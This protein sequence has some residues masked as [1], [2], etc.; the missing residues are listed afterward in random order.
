LTLPTDKKSDCKTNGEGESP[1]LNSTDIMKGL[2]L[3]PA[4]TDHQKKLLDTSEL[5]YKRY[6]RL[7]F[8]IISFE[9]NEITIKAF[10]RENVAEKYLTSKEIIERVH[11]VFDVLGYKVHVRPITFKKDDLANVDTAYVQSKMEALS[12]G[13]KDLVKLLNIDKSSLSLILSEGRMTRSNQAMFY[14][15]FKYLEEKGR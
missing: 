3:L 4:L 10:Q 1:L 2:E 8:E 7:Y 5:N 11:G 15:L 14:Y 6:A 12:L 9:N 13:Q